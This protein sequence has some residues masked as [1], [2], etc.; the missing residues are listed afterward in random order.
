MTAR[1]NPYVKHSKLTKPLI[2]FGQAVHGFGLEKSLLKLIEIRASQINGCGVCLDMHSREAVQGGERWERIVML[3]AWRETDLF[4]AREKAALAWTECL[5]RLA[6]QGAPDAI[7][8]QVKA[9]F[10]DEEQVALTLMIGTINI[11]N[12]LG[13]GFHIPPVSEQQLKQLQATAA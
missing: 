6:D 11:F 13:V 10:S 7:Y 3:D 4:T 9:E 1:P 2:A 5:T 12:R 8:D